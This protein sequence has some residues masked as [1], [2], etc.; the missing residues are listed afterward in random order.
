MASRDPIDEVT[1]TLQ[2]LGWIVTRH[3]E[4]SFSI[5]IIEN[6]SLPSGWSKPQTR[7]L[8]KLPA[9]FPHGKPDMFWTDT[10]LTLAGGQVPHKADLIEQI[11]GQEWRR[12]SWHPQDW[13]PGRDDIHT[14]LAFVARRFAQRK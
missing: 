14:F 3:A 2:R 8:L 6:Y 5:V 12:F 9:S 7:L 4:G 1:A 10:D 13:T 11:C